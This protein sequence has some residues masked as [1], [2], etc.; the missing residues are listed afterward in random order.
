L[1]FLMKSLLLLL[2]FLSQL[3]SPYKIL[4]YNSKFGHSNVNFYGNIADILV[5]AGHDVTSLIPEL[6]PS[7][8]NGTLK[9]K[10]IL[11]PQTKE[12]KMAMEILYSAEV[13]WF[14]MDNLN[15]WQIFD[16]TPY[17]DQ[18][19]HQ[20]KG[21]LDVTQLIKKLRKEKFDV[22]IAENFD[23]CGIGLVPLI[24]PKSLI[25]GAASVPLSFMTPEFGLPLAWST[26]PGPTI[27][28][29]DVNSF[30]SRMK[31]VY[32]ELLGYKFWYTSRS[33]VQQLFRDRFGPDYPSLVEI[34]SHAAYTI[35]NSE[36][37]LDYATPILSRVVYIGGLG[38]R[39]PK[40]L[41]KDLSDIVS[42]RNE[43]VL[44]SFGS[45]V[46][47]SELP[48]AVKQSIAKTV[49]NF[50]E[51][52]FI[53]KYEQPEDEFSEKIRSTA[54]NL[55]LIKWIP[56]NDLLADDRLTAFVTHCG[57]GSTQELS[58]RG[59]PGLFIPI[60]GDQMRNAG[61]MERSGVGKV[62][63]KLDLGNE[64]KLTAAFRDLLE[65]KKY[66]NNARR[67]AAMIAKKPFSAQELLIK[68]VEFAAEFGPSPALRPRSYDMNWIKYNNL[69]IIVS[70]L[71]I[72]SFAVYFSVKCLLYLSRTCIFAKS[73]LD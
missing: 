39:K 45:K 59:K 15:P 34:S 7:L 36:P 53:W 32:A 1:L 11:V 71:A 33:L 37:L 54:P 48:E 3:G 73:K 62:F 17:A 43:T 40:K 14:I 66:L 72:S 22:M 52:T 24:N 57:M 4:V 29:L 27:S 31:N 12:A 35:I 60:F 68:T 47:A 51:V 70:T 63:D 50:P 18:F 65:N 56:Q 8:T 21:V 5:D 2:L 64:R 55:H 13:N 23:M 61:M 67:L 20:C 25:N 28:D 42:I 26:N 16:A 38:A 19:V 44:I 9:S 49:A 10:R 41:S 6:D 69:D 58:L 46:V 30:W